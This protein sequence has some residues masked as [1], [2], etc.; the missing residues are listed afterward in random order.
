[1]RPLCLLRSPRVGLDPGFKE[2]RMIK[3]LASASLI[4]VVLLLIWGA[5]SQPSAGSQH[6]NV[7]YDTD[8]DGLI[9][10]SY[11]EQLNAIRLDLEGDAK[12]DGP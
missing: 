7:D 9:E 4:L 10:I 2:G 6:G 12:P 11:L 8:D 3:A 5:A 1:M